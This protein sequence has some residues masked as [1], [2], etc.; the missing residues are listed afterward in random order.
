[1]PPKFRR[2]NHAASVQE[3]CAMDPKFSLSGWLWLAL[4]SALAAMAVFAFGLSRTG[5]QQAL[6]ASSRPSATR[7]SGS[8][9][10]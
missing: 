9:T 4:A 10:L 3:G 8:S 2:A 5:F 6:R 1:M 7:L